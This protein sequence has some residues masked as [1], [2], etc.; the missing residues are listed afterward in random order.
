MPFQLASDRHNICPACEKPVYFAEQVRIDAPYR[1][2]PQ[3]PIKYSSQYLHKNCF[4]CFEC[5]TK[6]KLGQ[7]SARNN[8]LCCS[9]CYARK[10]GPHG[11]R[12]GVTGGLMGISLA[13]NKIKNS[14]RRFSRKVLEKAS[15]KS[16]SGSADIEETSL[17]LKT[18]EPGNAVVN[19]ISVPTAPIDNEMLSPSID[20]AEDKTVRV[21]KKA[22]ITAS[23]LSSSAAKECSVYTSNISVQPGGTALLIIDPQ[24]DFH[25]GG[26]LAV[27]NADEDAA[28]I[29][30]LIEKEL[31][32]L[33]E[34]YVTL[35]SH[36]KY[37]I[38][39]PNFWVTPG[40]EN[41]AKPEHP[42]HFTV[43]KS[44]DIENKTWVARRK[45]HRLWA[46][47]YVKALEEQGRFELTIWPPHCLLGTKGHC[48]EDG[49]LD[50]LDAWE[51]ASGKSVH[52]ILKGTNSK[53]EHYSAIKAEVVVPEDEETTGVNRA[54]VDK[55]RLHDRIL[56]CGQALSHCVNYTTRDLVSEWGDKP[57]SALVIL[58]DASSP[59]AG[60][61]KDGEK[62]I[63]DMKDKGLAVA[64]STNE[65]LCDLEESME[66]S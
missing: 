29:K 28:R 10:F 16:L 18:L 57:M 15:G 36:M 54:L 35:D 1:R 56:I 4:R 40:T 31:T 20:M 37:H 25:P 61:Q 38:A 17:N 60:F 12:G 19:T 48:V 11:F 32:N 24:N 52:Y 30:A 34:I 8:S 65:K 50:A 51:E 39:H 21:K 23:K 3:S 26:S 42:S 7:H 66:S 22:G 43:I 62:F 2:N 55:L 58:Q 64:E 6:L 41:S 63:S 47:D 44:E 13:A 5:N 45:E 27:E 59:V 9:N 53:T 49:I 33:S 46:Y 14:T